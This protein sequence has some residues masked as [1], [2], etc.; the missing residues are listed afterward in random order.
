[1]RR[2]CASS[3]CNTLENP[4]VIADA[5]IGRSQLAYLTAAL[6]RV[7]SEK[8]EGALLIANHHPPYTAGSNKGWSTDM[9]G[10]IDKMDAA[11]HPSGE[12]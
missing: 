9:L 2:S 12:E 10:Q 11:D 3:R 4:G 8:Y 7:K 1:M 5:N 6:Q